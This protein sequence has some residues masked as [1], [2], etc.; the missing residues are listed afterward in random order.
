M[1]KVSFHFVVIWGIIGFFFLIAAYCF[2]GVENNIVSE[3]I[4]AL[5]KRQ[6]MLLVGILSLIGLT[7]SL[8]LLNASFLIRRLERMK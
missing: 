1:K 5:G 7:V 3:H 2:I 6:W 8:W 4:D